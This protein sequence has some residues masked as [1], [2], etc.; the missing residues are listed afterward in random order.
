VLRALRRDPAGAVGRVMVVWLG[1]MP[2]A[3]KP[4]GGLLWIDAL[5]GLPPLLPGWKVP[6][7]R[8]DV[9][10]CRQTAMGLPDGSRVW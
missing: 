6:R 7:S 3:S 10:H 8:L 2:T 5:D 9:E 1:K 4:G